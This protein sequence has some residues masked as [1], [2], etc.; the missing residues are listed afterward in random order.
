M[1]QYVAFILSKILC[2]FN[3][4]FLYIILFSLGVGL[5]VHKIASAELIEI[6]GGVGGIEFTDPITKNQ[7]LTGISLRTGDWVTAIHGLTDVSTL[8]VHGGITGEEL[9]LNWPAN[10]QIVRIY[11]TYADYIKTISFVT[12]TGRV[13]GPYG[14]HTAQHPLHEFDITVPEGQVI[15]GFKGRAGAYLNA[16]GVVYAP[17]SA[18]QDKQ[19]AQLDST[20]AAPA[21]AF[22]AGA[23]SELPVTISNRG[24]AVA[25]A[26]IKFTLPLPNK[27]DA[28]Y[29]IVRNNDAWLCLRSDKPS[30]LNCTYSKPLLPGD[31]TTL[32]V[33]LLP[34][35][36]S[37]GLLPGTFV[38]H[39][40]ANAGVTVMSS[41][42]ALAVPQAVGTVN[43]ASVKHP[44]Y[45][46]PVLNAA[47]IPKYA[48]P[49]TNL[50][51]PHFRFLPDV[52]AVAN[53][54]LYR[55]D[56][57]KIQAQILPPGYPAT[58]VYAYGDC[59]CKENFSYPA[60]TI[61]ENSTTVGVNR[62]KRGKPTKIQFNDVRTATDPHLLP[63][64]HSIHG[65][66]DGE[67]DIRS[68]VHLHGFKQVVQN[69]D[70]YPEAWKSPS[71]AT[72]NQFSLTSPTVPFNPAAFDQANN[73]EAGLL[74]FHD[75]TLGMTRLNVYS[76]LTG[77]HEQ[78]LIDK[79]RLP[80]APY[81][82]ALM[83]QDRMF[84][85]DGSLAYPDRNP[86][87]PGAPELSMLPEFFGN[88]MLVNGVAWPYLDVEPRKYRFRLINGSNSRFYTLSLSNKALFQMLGTEGGFLPA[89]VSVKQLTIAPGERYDLIIDF[90]AGGN[91]ILQNSA[92]SP[93]PNG[94]AV[95]KGLHDQLMQFRVILPKLPA[96]DA[97]V[98]GNLRY[99]PLSVLK[100][101]K[102]R[103]VLLA[104]VE[105]NDSRILPMLGTVEK[106]VLGWM[107][108]ITE[109]VKAN[110]TEI[111]EI[112]NTTVDAHPV[113]LHGGHFQIVNRQAVSYK[114]NKDTGALSNIK[115]PTAA[116]KPPL[117]ERTWKDTVIALPGQVTRI[118]VKFEGKGLFV[119]HCHILEHEDHDMMRPLL[120]K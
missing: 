27:V 94:D 105:D 45:S 100:P 112:Y 8:P 81:E 80:G 110:S 63:V 16:L 103:R 78:D 5:A 55:M 64:D 118:T 13:L 79:R 38:V 120:V 68:V 43:L 70:G 92:K 59:T 93:F 26:P 23:L 31:S 4:R 25:A 76:G 33:P 87:V 98:S 34:S 51:S 46:K 50:L 41:A 24:L 73:Q 61:V 116:I 54:D 77:L 36:T 57:D 104:E 96:P 67:P 58:T 60:H 20:I 53:T 52:K 107:D 32:R 48:L 72:G 91:I 49:L 14:K 69:S 10:E 65:A 115:F 3:K 62:L 42:S 9:Q 19:V 84:Y 95:V 83:L 37:V 71:G 56:I 106:G 7:R 90:S 89:P 35:I 1:N 22:K 40:H 82:V 101:I 117:Q 111:W 86:D 44:N 119:W 29:K 113:H 12:N 17:V 108:E 15:V 66:T 6:Q 102:T 11:G 2:L 74:W 85:P 28:P 47:N 21:P 88:V 109:V 114:R 99:K 39:L 18:P 97:I 30:E 75:H